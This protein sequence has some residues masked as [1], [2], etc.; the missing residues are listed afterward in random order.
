MKTE[1]SMDILDAN[2]RIHFRDGFTF[3]IQDDKHTV[4]VR[5]MGEHTAKTVYVDMQDLLT[6]IKKLEA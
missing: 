5:I 4:E 2:R 3:S 6:A 1:V